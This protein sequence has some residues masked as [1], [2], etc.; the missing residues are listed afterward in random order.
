MSPSDYQDLVRPMIEGSDNYPDTGGR[1]EVLPF[2]QEGHRVYSGH[3]GD[4]YPATG[5]RNEVLPFS[6]EGQTI[7][8]GTRPDS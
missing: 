6:Q 8:S 4:N 5:G 7:A 2:S 3:M 1:N